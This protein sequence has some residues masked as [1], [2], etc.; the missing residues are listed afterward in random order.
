MDRAVYLWSIDY[1]IT[2][3]FSRTYIAF[4]VLGGLVSYSPN[5]N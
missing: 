2:R 1:G 4:L 3:F 5:L